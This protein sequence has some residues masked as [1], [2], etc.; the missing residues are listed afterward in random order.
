MRIDYL[1]EKKRDHENKLERIANDNL[2][3]RN[4]L[5][6]KIQ[7]QQEKHEKNR[8]EFLE[9]RVKGEKFKVDQVMRKRG[10]LLD[11]RKQ[12]RKNNEE[13][14]KKNRDDTKQFWAEK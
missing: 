9:K 13:V 5:R 2:N 12:Q 10:E 1:L 7:Q 3:K 11:K 4:Q 8:K 6:D 14:F